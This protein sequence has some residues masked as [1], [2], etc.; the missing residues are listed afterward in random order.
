ME[1]RQFSTGGLLDA[2]ELKNGNI[3]ERRGAVRGESGR[4]GRTGENGEGAQNFH[5]MMRGDTTF[6]YESSMIRLLEL[7]ILKEES[8][9]QQ[10]I[11]TRSEADLG[12]VDENRLCG[13]WNDKQ[14]RR[15]PPL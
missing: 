4:T 1:I 7:Q 8:D 14:R 9:D 3:W 6:T 10:H 13:T 2:Q 11:H 12:Y 15:N 5:F